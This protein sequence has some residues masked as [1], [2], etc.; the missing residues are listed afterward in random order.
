MFFFQTDFVVKAG[1]SGGGMYSIR[2]LYYTLARKCQNLQHCSLRGFAG[3]TVL[4]LALQCR[5]PMNVKEVPEGVC[6][7][8]KNVRINKF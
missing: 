5:S 1:D 2:I 4:P 8:Q 6:M 3:A 7:G